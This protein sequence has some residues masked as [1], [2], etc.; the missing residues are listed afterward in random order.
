MNTEIFDLGK[1]GITLGGEYDNKV[2]YEKLTIVLYKGKSYIST[3]TTQGVSPEQDILVWQLVAEAKDA[4]HMLVDTGKTTLTEEEFLE[5]LVDATKGRYIVQG[6]IINAA[7]EEDL[8]VEHSD[9][10]GI[11]TLKLANRD[12][13]NGMGYVILRKNKSFAEQVTKENTI[14]EIRYD[15]DLK[16]NE[17]KIPSNCILRFIG[18]KIS[19]GNISGT[20]VKLQNAEID[21]FPSSESYFNFCYNND[22]DVIL[23]SDIEISKSCYL[24][25]IDGKGHTIILKGNSLFTNNK[26]NVFIK[27]VVIKR[28]DYCSKV[29]DA[30]GGYTI[31]LNGNGILDVLNVTFD[32][33]NTYEDMVYD[34]T[35]GLRVY[36]AMFINNHVGGCISNVVTRNHAF[37]F[38]IIGCKHLSFFTCHSYNTQVMFNVS[39]SE[40]LEVDNCH[41]INNRFD[42]CWVINGMVN[43][44]TNGCDFVLGGGESSVYKNCSATYAVER[45]AY[46]SANHIKFYNCKAINCGGFKIVGGSSDKITVDCL[47]KDCIYERTSDFEE[48]NTLRA[49]NFYSDAP[50]TVPDVNID[51]LQTY[52]TDGVIYDNLTAINKYNLN[53]NFGASINDAANIKIINSKFVNIAAEAE[54]FNI[55]NVNNVTFSNCIFDNAVAKSYILK[56]HNFTNSLGEDNINVIFDKCEM[57]ISSNKFS[58]RAIVYNP[59]NAEIRNCRLDYYHVPNANIFYKGIIE[60][61]ALIDSIITNHF[62]LLVISTDLKF[63]GKVIG[64]ICISPLYNAIYQLDQPIHIIEE[65]ATVYTIMNAGKKTMPSGGILTLDYLTVA[66][67]QRYVYSLQGRKA[68]YYIERNNVIKTLIDEFVGSNLTVTPG[69]DSNNYF[70]VKVDGA[71][72]SGERSLEVE[73][74][75]LL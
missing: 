5:Q 55:Y 27:N 15:F 71:G 67:Q 22:I 70:F 28:D 12:N 25:N 45:F 58:C 4:Y 18:G 14:Y 3:K 1:I 47:F 38:R 62:N 17:V 2:I 49:A 74:P 37:I 8:T 75:H 36:G 20:K 11:D 48:G 69:I 39:S 53:V 54:L 31:T 7:D 33:V 32:S 63:Q 34:E 10:L 59:T 72:N 29:S 9:L 26:D 41:L 51:I 57:K 64:C 52:Y 56:K 30:N 66:A 61:C 6:N 44:G 68:V 13:T 16:N 35:S 24:P 43:K 65:G 50:I 60:N 21:S 40:I 19:N 46:G 42:S 73:I 23:N